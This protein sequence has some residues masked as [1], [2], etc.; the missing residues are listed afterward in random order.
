MPISPE[1]LRKKIQAKLDAGKGDSPA[2]PPQDSPAQNPTPTQNPTT[3]N[4]RVDD[5]FVAESY[6][7]PDPIQ[8]DLPALPELNSTGFTDFGGNNL[9][10][11]FDRS[12]ENQTRANTQA[13]QANN[14][15]S[16]LAARQ[17]FASRLQ[18][19]GYDPKTAG[20]LNNSSVQQQAQGLGVSASRLNQ[21]TSSYLNPQEQPARPTPNRPL[22]SQVT[23]NQ[24][25][26]GSTALG[27]TG[28]LR[29]GG[30]RT[31]G[32]TSGKA[33]PGLISGND[34]DGRPNLPNDDGSYDNSWSGDRQQTPGV[35]ER[36]VKD[37]STQLR[38][39]SRNAN[40]AYRE[41]ILIG[42]RA[43]AEKLKAEAEAN[44]LVLGGVG[45]S[46]QFETTARRMLMP[47]TSP[48]AEP[49]GFFGQ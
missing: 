4:K 26:L 3:Q 49:D 34:L 29:T 5:R 21:F 28:G 43:E 36:D 15:S 16:L 18:S 47:Q 7:A 45:R 20:N 10:S 14:K 22:P 38:K 39:D 30:L 24:Q 35:S 48:M 37:L 33:G 11:S 13:T 40:L 42:K 31:G 17:D 41:L 12:V 9:P 27:G 2:R 1:E 8:G 32:L 46:G 25:P 44:G 19:G 23:Q 6:K